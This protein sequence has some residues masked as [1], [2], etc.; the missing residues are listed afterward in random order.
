MGYDIK[1][2]IN[3]KFIKTI[4]VRL[5]RELF[6]RHFGED[7]MPVAFDGG[8]T[9]IRSALTTY[10]GEPVTDWKEGLVADLH[11]VAEL[12]GNEGMQLILN[13][14]RRQG[15]LLYP[16]PD[17]EDTQSAPIKHDAKHVALHNRA[18]AIAECPRAR[19]WPASPGPPASGPFHP[20][21]PPAP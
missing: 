7:A 16:D 5:M 15:V 2:F 12:G 1:R 13:E 20:A 6:V 21:C 19:S 3:P 11:R 10:F 14:A 8:A 4:D 17:P 18:I 9:A